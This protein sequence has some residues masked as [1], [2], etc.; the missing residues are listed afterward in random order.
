MRNAVLVLAL[1]LLTVT[2]AA[3]ELVTLD[4]ARRVGENFLAWKLSADGAWGDRA[5][6]RAADCVPLVAA[7]RVYAYW[8]PVEPAGHL[9][10][11]P[12][13]ELP[14]IKAWSDSDDFRPDLDHGYP[15]LIRDVMTASLDFLAENHGSLEHLPATVAPAENRASWDLWLA[16]GMGERGRDIVGPLLTTNWDQDAPFWNDCPD[17]DGGRCLVGCVATSAAMIM[18]YWEYPTSGLGTPSYEWDGD[19]SCGGLVGGGVL[20]ANLLDPYDWANITSNYDGG[21]TAEEI[22]AVAELNYE[23]AVT[24]EMD[25]GHCAS[26]S[27]VSMGEYVYHD[28]FDYIDGAAYLE[29]SDYDEDGWWELIVSELTQMPPRPIHYRIYQHSIICDGYQDNTTRYYHMNYGWG[30]GANSWYALDNLYC[31]WPGCDVTEE[32]L[33]FGVEPRNYFPVS[34]PGVATVWSHD[35]EPLLPVAWS[36]SAATQVQVDLYKGSLFVAT[37]IAW[38]ANDGSEPLGYAVPATW[39]TGSNFRLKVVGDDGKFGW[40]EPFGIYGAGGWSDATAGA[41]LNDAGNGQGVA[42]GDCDGDDW[43]D[44]YLST[45]MTG[46]GLFGNQA[47]LSFTDITAAPLDVTGHGR[48]TAWADIDNDGDL[49]LYLAQTTGHA[50]HLFRND[51]GSFTDITAGPLGD[52]SYSS[53]I[54]WGDYDADGLIDLFVVN[55]YA[56]DRLLRN[57][58]GGVFVDVTANPLGDGGWGRS[59][60]W[61]DYDNDGDLDLYL[62]RQNANKL[63][64]NDGGSFSDVSIASGAANSG[65]G[66]GAAWGD[67]DNDGDLDL[68]IANQGANALLINGGGTFSDG[69]AS[70]LDDAGSGRAVAWGDYDNDGWLDLYLSNSGGGNKLFRNA[71]DGSFTEATDPLLGDENN[72]EGAAWCDYDGDGDLDLYLANA[73]A[74]NRLFRNE[75]GGPHWVQLDLE[76]TTSNRCGVGAWV[77]LEAG[78]LTQYRQVGGDAG[79][80]SQNSRVVA[81]GLGEAGTIDALEVT[82]PSGTVISYAGL[83]ADQRHHCLEDATAVGEAAP[84]PC[85]LIGNHPNPFN[86]D[87]KIAFRLAEA[88]RVELVVYDLSGRQLRALASDRAFAA[89]THEIAWD[90]RDDAGHDL[91]SGVYFYRLRAADFVACKRMVLLK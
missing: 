58:G 49:D 41:P 30:G 47:G 67:V 65:N 20:S 61:G 64:R 83:A 9:I 36:G 22:A 76:G 17:G 33:V 24:F 23:V 4:E 44:I 15:R 81:F 40:S 84:A 63:Y 56:D 16:G 69:T 46:N 43:P 73:D 31:D 29:R 38:T 80:L 50:N 85:E 1:I 91:A 51:G 25:F 66:Y 62:V 78:G 53:D 52:T 45:E 60:E 75:N 89:G 48:G 86:P 19:D 11:S 71:G 79:Y 72:G 26:G 55:V 28:Y 70:P 21:S 82:W 10:V 14:A 54:A 35:E 13:R 3:A 27:Y 12:I 42:W 90:G 32:G 2:T 59:A 39:G 5:T 74:D 68:Y 34:E 7:G 77:R 87:T 37:A 6:A 8:L 57:T 18:K 88:A